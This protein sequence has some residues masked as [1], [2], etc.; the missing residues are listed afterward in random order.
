MTSCE[1]GGPHMC[2][3]T[4]PWIG[5]KSCGSYSS[6]VQ[7]NRQVEQLGLKWVRKVQGVCNKL[8]SHISH[9]VKQNMDLFS[10]QKNMD[11]MN[12]EREE[13]LQAV[14]W[15]FRCKCMDENKKE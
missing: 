11:C 8:Q 6:I 3:L 5:T 7:N 9:S 13:G 1:G 12:R 2:K 10:A 15:R 4:G 14:A